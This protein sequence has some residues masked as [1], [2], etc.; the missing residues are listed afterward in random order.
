MRRLITFLILLLLVTGALY[1]WGLIGK[2]PVKSIFDIDS[3]VRRGQAV[4]P[5]QELNAKGIE[6]LNAGNPE[7]AVAALRE[8]IRLEP[9]NSV[10]KRNLSIA[11]ARMGNGISGDDPAALDLL[12]ESL[13]LWPKNPESLDGLSTIHF[14]AGR[15]EEALRSAA[16][17][18][19]MMPDRE[20]LAQYVSHLQQKVADEK[21]MSSESGDRFRLLYSDERKLEYSGEIL[22]ILQSQLDSLSVSLGIFPEK[23]IDVLLLTKDLGDRANPMDPS[24]EGLYDGQIRLYAGEGITDRR[25]FIRTVRHEMVHALLHQGAGNLPGWVHEGLAQLVGEEP[26]DEHKARL[27]SYLA[28]KIREGYRIELEKMGVSFLNLDNESRTRAYASSLLFMDH[29]S[30]TYGSGFV[31]RFISEITSGLP[32]ED[33]LKTLTGQDFSSLQGAFSDQLGRNY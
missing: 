16:V 27:R 20:D 14:R 24:L 29:L 8:S 4:G 12:E 7:G 11:L 6:E 26:D 25:K 31:A 15:Y 32:P 3:I 1:F 28:E 10:I 5:G 17:L 23:T 21:G 19:E 13:E 18:Q 33:A 30:S 22:S 2:S 9:A